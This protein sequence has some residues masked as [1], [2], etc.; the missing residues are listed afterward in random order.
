M[1]FFKKIKFSIV[2]ICR[3][4]KYQPL[5]KY[6]GEKPNQIFFT[7]RQVAHEV[8]RGRNVVCIIE[9]FLHQRT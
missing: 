6:E 5:K 4:L 8:S 9:I 1:K 7:S 2:N 3:L